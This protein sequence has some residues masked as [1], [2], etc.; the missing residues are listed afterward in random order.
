MKI[1]VM[2][3]VDYRGMNSV[4][5]DLPCFKTVDLTKNSRESSVWWRLQRTSRLRISI[6]WSPSSTSTYLTGQPV[7]I[8]LVTLWRRLFLVIRSCSPYFRLDEMTT[9]SY[10]DGNRLLLGGSVSRAFPSSISLGED[11]K[12][13]GSSTSVKRKDARFSLIQRRKEPLSLYSAGCRVGT[14]RCQHPQ[15]GDCHRLPEQTQGWYDQGGCPVRDGKDESKWQDKGRGTKES[16]KED[17]PCLFGELLGYWEV[18]YHVLQRCITRSTT[19]KHTY[20]PR[21][22]FSSFPFG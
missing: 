8:F 13:N 9:R 2:G 12:R 16:S 14:S 1:S 3:I 20:K 10:R 11:S 6:C 15:Q 19:N 7:T 4:I 17:L 18:I 21:F 22:P 5:L